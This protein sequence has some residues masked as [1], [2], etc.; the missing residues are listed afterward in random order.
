[1]ICAGL[2]FF[3]V[4][5]SKMKFS[6]EYTPYELV[7]R[8][9]RIDRVGVFAGRS[10]PARHKVV[11]YTGQRI[12]MSEAYRRF[13]RLMRAKGRKRSYLAALS[14]SWAIDGAVGGNGSEL[15]NHSCDPNLFWKRERGKLIFYAKRRIRRGEELTLDYHFPAESPTVKCLCRSPK[16]RGTINVRK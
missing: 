2:T 16:C 7:L 3:E 14:R 4:S 10:I 15:I 12:R 6:S 13:R 9:S 8:K 11:E 1:M 5:T